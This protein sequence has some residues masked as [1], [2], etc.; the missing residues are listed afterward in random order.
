MQKANAEELRHAIM[1]VQAAINAG[2]DF[3]P[4][5][6]KNAEHKEALLVMMEKATQEIIEMVE[7]EEAENESK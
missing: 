2:M 3:V 7:R 5:P 4:I 1:R 6:V